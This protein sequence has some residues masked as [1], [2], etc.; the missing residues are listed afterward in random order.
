MKGYR[1]AILL[2]GVTLAPCVGGAQSELQDSSWI[3]ANDT[4][5][6]WSRAIKVKGTRGVIT[7]A[8]IDTLSFVAP[9]GFRKIPRE[10]VA[11]V[12][13]IERIDVLDGRKRSPWRVL[14]QMAL[15]GVLG[16]TAGG[17]VGYGVG[18]LVYEANRDAHE[19]S[20]WDSRGLAQ[21]IF[22]SV[23]V[24]VGGAVGIV[25]GGIDGMRAREQWRRIK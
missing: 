23:G 19:D 8:T 20:D 2:A 10:Y 17:L 9:A 6:V 21:F 25:G 24:S 3:R 18:N 16:A 7:R 12:A 11:N 13:S 5:R 22:V 14:G 4:V 15:G 1:A